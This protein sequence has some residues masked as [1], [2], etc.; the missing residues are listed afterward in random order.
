MR[1][2][3]YTA[4]STLAFA[5][6]AAAAA[7]VDGGSNQVAAA[8]SP[9]Q[10]DLA[11]PSG[12]SG[13][14]DKVVGTATSTVS[15]VDLPQLTP[16][17]Q[18]TLK[19][20]FD[21]IESL[22]ATAAKDPK[23]SA[24]IGKALKIIH[25]QTKKIVGTANDR[26]IVAS[27]F[28]QVIEALV[29]SKV[30]S[31]GAA[32]HAKRDGVESDPIAIISGIVGPIVESLLGKGNIDLAAVVDSLFAQKGLVNRVLD[33]LGPVIKSLPI[34]GPLLGGKNGLLS[35]VLDA[36]VDLIDGLVGTTGGLA[37]GPLRKLDDDNLG[38][39]TKGSDIGR[40]LGGPAN[41]ILRK[42]DAGNLV[43]DI[44]GNAANVNIGDLL[45]VGNSI[46]DLPGGAAKGNTGSL[47]DDVPLN[48]ILGKRDDGNSIGDLLDDINIDPVVVGDIV[49]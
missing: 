15:K 30:A 26:Q 22:K 29:S 49:A 7:P 40:L 23:T 11:I 31:P 34:I 41:D 44:L 35:P 36:S 21:A 32:P 47:L 39:I 48:D 2:V 19:P 46:G 33:T 27:I 38:G 14:V 43:G 37:G 3:K 18:Q 13:P 42:R 5:L 17:Q 28:T 16:E 25:D 1:F 45:D 12:V 6:A 8:I 20:V 9:Q 10:A 4:I 24:D